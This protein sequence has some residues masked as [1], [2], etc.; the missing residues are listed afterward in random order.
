[1]ANATHCIPEDATCTICNPRE[2]VR[3]GN[4]IPGKSPRNLRRYQCAL[5]EQRLDRVARWGCGSV[6]GDNKDLC[7]KDGWE[8]KLRRSTDTP[9]GTNNGK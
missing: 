3:S 6:Y 5:C 9:E 1:M 8:A 7:A 4:R 2:R